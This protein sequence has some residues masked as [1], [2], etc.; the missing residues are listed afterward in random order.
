M[1]DLVSTADVNDGRRNTFES[2]RRGVRT[3]GGDESGDEDDRTCDEEVGDESESLSSSN[4]KQ[5]EMY[6]FVLDQLGKLEERILECLAEAEQAVSASND[7]KEGGWTIV[8]RRVQGRT[9]IAMSWLPV[10][11]KALDLV[12][13]RETLGSRVLFAQMSLIS[14]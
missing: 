7:E 1:Q 3:R 10:R 13:Q 2:F 4:P 12:R 9:D 14:S 11:A 8:P 6:S 5:R